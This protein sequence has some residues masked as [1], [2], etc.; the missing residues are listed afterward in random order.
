[1]KKIAIDIALL[2]SE[3]MMNR[4]IKTNEELTKVS[5]QKI[6]LDKKTCLPH[7]SLVIG[8]VNVSD[9]PKISNVLQ[10]ISK[11]Y[12][13]FNLTTEGFRTYTIE[14]GEELSEF[15]ISKNKLLQDI[16]EDILNSLSEYLVDDDLAIDM[17]Y[18]PPEV[19]DITMSWIR[20]FVQNPGFKGY[21]PHITL[22]TG[23]GNNTSQPIEFTSSML[24]LCHIGNYCT[25]RNVLFST[26]L[27]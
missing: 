6:K 19:E 13:S 15:T 3:E 12:S 23:E 22:G 9:I 2:P 20:H 10:D 24:A 11:K 21:R 26:D 27:G 4:S 18:S 7:I 16:H 25:C 5:V 14:T 8:V 1:M 17:V